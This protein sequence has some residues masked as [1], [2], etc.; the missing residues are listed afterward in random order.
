M[1]PCVCQ[2]GKDGSE[3]ENLDFVRFYAQETIKL[4]SR[5]EVLLI[6]EEGSRGDCPGLRYD[7][8]EDATRVH[9][10]KDQLGLSSLSLPHSPSSTLSLL[11]LA[12][13]VCSLLQLDLEKQLKPAQPAEIQLEISFI[14]ALLRFPRWA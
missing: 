8:T 4:H 10:H 3:R 1:S 14:N 12:G 13:F 6:C 9:K 7:S 11:P 2:K 5:Q